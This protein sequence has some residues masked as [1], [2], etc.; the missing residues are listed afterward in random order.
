VD[1]ENGR[2]HRRC[3]PYFL[4]QEEKNN[5]SSPRDMV[6][7]LSLM[8]DGKLLGT[9]SDQRMI[10]IMRQ[11]KTNARIP[12]KLPEGTPVAHKTGSIDHLT[13]DCGIVYT[14]N[15]DYVLTLFYNGNLASEEEYE[16]TNWG[17]VGNSILSQLSADIYNAYMQ[18]K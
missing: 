4:C 1:A 6:K 11:C 7:L 16:G 12:A 15:G 14:D 13:N 17:D 18:S 8:Y 3:S 2:F 5:Q 10:D 9:D